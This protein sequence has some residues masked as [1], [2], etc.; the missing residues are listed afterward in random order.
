[1]RAD[2]VAMLIPEDGAGAALMVR[3][4]DGRIAFG[5]IDARVARAARAAAVRGVL[6]ALAREG[7]P[8]T[9]TTLPFIELRRV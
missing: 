1:M 9:E 4:L 7:V 3:R 6:R 5:C 8:E 2:E